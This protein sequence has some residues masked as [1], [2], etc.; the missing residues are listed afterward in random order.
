MTARVAW[1]TGRPQMASPRGLDPRDNGMRSNVWTNLIDICCAIVMDCVIRVSADSIPVVAR[2]RLCDTDRVVLALV[3]CGGPKHH[4]R[5][6]AMINTMKRVGDS[7]WRKRRQNQCLTLIMRM[8]ILCLNSNGC[9]TKR[10]YPPCHLFTHAY[11]T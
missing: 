5:E 9:A 11:A 1:L 6:H 4:A 10:R 8:R 2:A 3:I 7:I